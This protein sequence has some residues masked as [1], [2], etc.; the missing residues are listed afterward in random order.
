MVSEFLENKNYEVIK[1]DNNNQEGHGHILSVKVVM[2]TFCQANCEFCFNKLTMST[3]QHNWELFKVNIFESLNKL[4]SHLDKRKISIDITGNEPTFDIEKFKWLMN[5]LYSYKTAYKDK[6]DKIVLTSN[7]YHLFECIEYMEDIVDIV[8]ISLHYTSYKTRQELFKTKLIPS[9]ND[10]EIINKML[11]EKNIKCT[12]VAVFSNE[13][14]FKYIVTK[15][16]KFSKEL[17]FD[18]TR[19]R[20]DFTTK[21][22]RVKN[23]FDT[24]FTDDEVVYNQNGLDSKYFN[25]DGYNVSIYRGVPEL[26]DYVIGVEAVI[27]DNGIIYL[28]YNKNLPLDTEDI[29]LFND[30]IYIIN[31]N[32]KED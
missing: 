19:I 29:C 1:I 10:I 4:F 17:G 25:I 21:N 5:T 7:G 32:G 15:F 28:D 8:N 26:I 12:S 3:Q 22:Q 20:I 14:A 24:K 31:N 23:M 30:N 13:C 11:K 9:N 18:D 16:A 2:P 6:I 27:D